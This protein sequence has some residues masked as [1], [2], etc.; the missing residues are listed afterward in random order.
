MTP[1][2]GIGFIFSGKRNIGFHLLCIETSP[3][4]SRRC[5]L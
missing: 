1:Y 5:D 2:R 3:F 4:I